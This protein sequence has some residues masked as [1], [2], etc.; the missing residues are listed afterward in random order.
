MKG[1]PKGGIQKKKVEDFCMRVSYL[2]SLHKLCGRKGEGITKCAKA[3]NLQKGE[4]GV[5]ARENSSN[6]NEKRRV[7]GKDTKA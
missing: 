1:Q 7:L 4:D 5:P 3:K 2:S 6:S